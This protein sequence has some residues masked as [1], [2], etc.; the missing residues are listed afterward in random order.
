[1]TVGVTAS[2]TVVVESPMAANADVSCSGTLVRK[3][4]VRKTPFLPL[5]EEHD[6]SYQRVNIPWPNILVK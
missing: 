6:G 2:E 3:I 5:K 4:G 1:M